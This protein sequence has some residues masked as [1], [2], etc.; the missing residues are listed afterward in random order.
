MFSFLFFVSFVSNFIMSLLSTSPQAPLFD[1]EDVASFP[2]S[3]FLIAVFIVIRL[4]SC[5]F[6]LLTSWLAKFRYTST[7][8]DSKK[9]I[10]NIFLNFQ[11]VMNPA[12]PIQRP[13]G[14]EQTDFDDNKPKDR[15]REGSCRQGVGSQIRANRKGVGC[16]NWSKHSSC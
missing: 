12:T 1:I 4:A 10:T 16:L 15:G 6:G 13:I 2:L 8:N 14:A 9:S 11:F 7:N 5:S 3:I